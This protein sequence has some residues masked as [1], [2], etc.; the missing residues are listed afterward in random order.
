LQLKLNHT[1]DNFLIYL[2][3]HLEAISEV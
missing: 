3:R 1:I 2:G